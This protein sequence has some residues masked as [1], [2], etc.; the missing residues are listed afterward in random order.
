M[1]NRF[2]VKTAMVLTPILILGG[3]VASVIVM[4]AMRPKPE[5]A[6]QAPPGLAVFVQDAVVDDYAIAVTAQGEVRARQEIDLS[7]QVPGRITFVSDNLLE[8]R[9]FRKGDV[10]VRL[11]DADYRLAVTRASANVATARQRLQ[12]EEAEAAIAVEDLSALGV[13]NASP[14][15]RREPQLAEARAALAA[16]EATL[17]DAEL[18]LSRTVV[19]APFDGRVREK[20][21]D[22]GQYVGPGAPLARVFGTEV[23]E[24]AL[25]LS[26]AELGQVGLP[27]AFIAGRNEPGPS[28]TLSAPVAG[29]RRTWEAQIVRT[30]AAIDPRTRVV[31]AVAEINDPFGAAASNGAPLAPGLFVTASI[32]GRVFE[33]VTLIPRAGLRGL[34]QVYVAE[35]GLMRVRTVSVL[36]TDPDRAVISGGLA[37]GEAVITSPV[38]APFDGMTIRVVR[39]NG[40]DVAPPPKAEESTED[41]QAIAGETNDSRGG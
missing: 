38:Q 25:P 23:V 28:V 19:R 6:E 31:F 34:D 7:S 1:A 24:V 22:V 5:P 21:V 40:E 39:R 35:D 29:E 9:F 12:R 17:A 11:D 26:D 13:A 16:A 20:R 37:P 30:S 27:L 8:G 4:G 32:E 14:L 10:L 2:L 15:A 41:A 33:D 18:Q 3:G 36:H